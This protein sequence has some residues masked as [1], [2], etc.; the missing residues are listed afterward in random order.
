MKLFA[1]FPVRLHYANKCRKRTKRERKKVLGVGR[2]KWVEGEEQI[3]CALSNVW[4]GIGKMRRKGEGKATNI[5]I[6]P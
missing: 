5:I 2:E 3:Y 6:A 1:L 4:G